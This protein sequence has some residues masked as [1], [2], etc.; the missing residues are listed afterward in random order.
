LVQ[1]ILSTRCYF[2]LHTS[3]QQRVRVQELFIQPT[4]FS[5][6]GNKN[7]TLIMDPVDFI[8]HRHYH[9]YNQEVKYFFIRKIPQWEY[10]MI[11]ISYLKLSILSVFIIFI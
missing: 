11:F 10:N 8:T 7:V 2:G 6:K 3:S 4:D 5:I 1:E 9:H